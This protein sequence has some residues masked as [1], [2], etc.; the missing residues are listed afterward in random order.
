MEEKKQDDRTDASKRE[1]EREREAAAERR[2]GQETGRY[3][4]ATTSRETPEYA[5]QFHVV[6]Q[7]S[8]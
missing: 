2:K 6:G 1:R 3:R 4:Y 7:D 5:M 8:R